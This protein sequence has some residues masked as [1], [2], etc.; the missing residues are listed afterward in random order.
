MVAISPGLLATHPAVSTSAPSHRSGKPA[1]APP[2]PCTLVIGAG[3]TGLA[4]AV[5]LTRGRTPTPVVVWEAGSQV[6]G[7]ARSHRRSG[8]TFD[9]TGHWLHLRDP[10]AIAFLAQ[11]E[12]DEDDEVADAWTE[13][14]RETKVLIADRCL[15]FPFQANLHG[16]PAATVARCLDDFV[17]AQI[18]QVN[19]INQSDQVDTRGSR[20]HSFA[21]FVEGRFGRAMAELF[22]LPYNRKLWGPALDRLTADCMQRFLPQPDRAQIIAG[23]VGV[24]QVGLGYNARFRYPRAGGIDHLPQLLARRAGAGPDCEIFC[25][26]AL[27]SID[28]ERRV[29]QAA[30]QSLSFGSLVTTMPLPQLIACIESV[31]VAIREASQALSSV[32]WRY[33]DVATRV[34]VKADYHWAYV[35]EPRYPFFRV[36]IYSNALPAMAP[37]GGSS[38]YVELDDRSGPLDE[39]AIARGL[40][41]LGVIHATQDI[42]FMQERSID[43]AYVVQDH[44]HATHTQTIHNWLRSQGVYSCGRYG[45]WKY[46]SMEDALLD[47]MQAARWVRSG[48]SEGA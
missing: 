23:A 41:D 47:G 25:G 34:P 15:D 26:R 31:P 30:G 16:L 12:G 27:A 22:F 36:G 11:L 48:Q 2:S 10:R 28:L 13:I 7:K 24:P 21:E 9:I 20:D 46:S 8:Y 5:A 3:L 35:P 42:L 6:G 33:L 18:N 40:V 19:L 14:A 38:L 4:T 29:A 39:A 45:A 43:V 1:E 44:V 37:Q 32:G 17:S